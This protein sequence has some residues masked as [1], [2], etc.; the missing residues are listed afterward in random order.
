MRCTRHAAYK[1]VMNTPHKIVIGNRK[2][3]RPRCRR[4]DNVENNHKEAVCEIVGWMDI[5]VSLKGVW[6]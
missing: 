2:R 4:L 6:R 1:R 5:T 3:T